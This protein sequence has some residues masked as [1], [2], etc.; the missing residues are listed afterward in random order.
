MVHNDNL[1]IF[2]TR[3][4][5]AERVSD[6][7]AAALGRACAEKTKATLAVSGGS[8][9][10]PLYNALSKRP[11]DWARVRVTLVDERWTPPGSPGSNET[12]VRTSL[13]RNRAL[14]ATFEGMW[15]EGHDPPAAVARSEKRLMTTTPLTVVVL[16]LGVDGHTA[17]WF[18][19]ADG[20]KN[21]LGDVSNVAEI[22]AS[23]SSVVGDFTR[24][25]TLT[26]GAVRRAD[27]VCLYM[28]GEDK[29]AAYARAVAGGSV[30]D[31]PVRAIIKAR[32]DMWVC[33]SA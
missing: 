11:L 3:E 1:I 25:L 24:R 22:D 33:W 15:F 9:P 31:M 30:E 23:P 20:L 8:T 32:P 27:L 29:R 21:A 2:P 26:L 5:M 12:F 14:A 7:L 4:A 6:V 19:H 13:L 28:T 10:A 16:G 18:P 17:S